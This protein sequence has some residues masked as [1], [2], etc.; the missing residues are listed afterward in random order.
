MAKHMIRFR[1]EQCGKYHDAAVYDGVD[2]SKEPHMRETDETDVTFMIYEQILA[3]KRV[4][5]QM[6][7]TDS[8]IEDI[9]FLNAKKLI[10]SVK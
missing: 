8:Q 9:M 5:A 6:K 4:A 3:L 1:C 2:V 10:E 7:L